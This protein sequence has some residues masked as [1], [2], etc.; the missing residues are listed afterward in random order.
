MKKQ[1]F[2]IAALALALGLTACSS[3]TAET[4]AAATEAET[5]EAAESV[6]EE[7]MEEDYFYGFV[8]DVTETEVTVSGDDGNTVT[9]DYSEAELTGAE[10]IGVG[11][12]VE[13]IFLGQLSEGVTKAKSVDIITSEAALQAEEEAENMDP[14]VSG[15]V[16]AADDETLTLATEDGTYTFRTL[17]AQKVTK[18]GIKEGVEA[19]VTYYG[20]LEDTEDVPV[21]TRIVTEDAFD[22]DEAQITTLTGKAVEVGEDHVILET[23]DPENTLFSFAGQ[24]GMFDGIEV[25]DTV[26]VIYEGTLTD[27]AIVATGIK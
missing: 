23:S 5:T 4:T 16:E 12:E 10:E 2:I 25:G 17:I 13:V 8:D 11:D 18:D 26:T 21:A 7:N 1:Y 27:R 24:E 14:V 9:F 22:S 3:K 15:T 6:A 19:E 20:D